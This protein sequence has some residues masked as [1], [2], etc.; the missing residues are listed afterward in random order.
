MSEQS[1]LFIGYM[2]RLLLSTI[3]TEAI[4]CPRDKAVVY[5]D[6]IRVGGV[7]EHFNYSWHIAIE[8]GIFAK[9]N[10]QI[11]WSEQK[12]GTGAM[13]SPFTFVHVILPSTQLGLTLAFRSL[14]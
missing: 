5:M 3:F 13:V 11:E 7:P 2:L 14:P 1:R 10:V 4:F 8:R 9:H 12:A 6:T